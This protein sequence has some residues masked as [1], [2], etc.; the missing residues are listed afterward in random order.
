MLS[1]LKNALKNIKSEV[2]E[3]DTSGQRLVYSFQELLEKAEQLSMNLKSA[4]LPE[5]SMIG[6]RANNSINWIVW[7]MACLLSNYV[8]FALE[9]DYPIEDVNGLLEKYSLSLLVAENVNGKH[10]NLF[11]INAIDNKFDSIDRTYDGTRTDQRAASIL[12]QGCTAEGQLYA[13]NEVSIP[14]QEDFQGDI[15]VSGSEALAYVGLRSVITL[16]ENE[17]N[18]LARVYTENCMFENGFAPVQVCVANC[19]F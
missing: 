2:I 6:I 14:I 1:N 8:V 3:H 10:L 9:T 17:R 19:S 16:A 18:N 13:A 4:G 15:N 11:D 12:A 7:D 5:R